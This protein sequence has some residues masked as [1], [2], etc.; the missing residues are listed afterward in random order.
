MAG[1]P[2][3]NRA[4][5]P[6]AHWRPNA[7]LMEFGGEF[8]AIGICLSNDSPGDTRG[9]LSTA[10][11]NGRF[12]RGITLQWFS[13]GYL[14]LS[15]RQIGGGESLANV[16]TVADAPQLAGKVTILGGLG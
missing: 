4:A 5:L 3:Q 6:V 16:Q 13:S 7:S 11:V 8:P 15:C 12:V 2:L 9:K 10:A 14:L 1:Q